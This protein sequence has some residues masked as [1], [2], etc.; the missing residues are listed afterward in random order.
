MISNTH[1]LKCQRYLI[2]SVIK[3]Y[4]FPHGPRRAESLSLRFAE[5]FTLYL[6]PTARVTACERWREGIL[7]KSA[8]PQLQRLKVH[9]VVLSVSAGEMNL[10]ASHV[11]RKKQIDKALRR[12]AATL[13]HISPRDPDSQHVRNNQDVVATDL[14]LA[15]LALKVQSYHPNISVYEDMLFVKQAGDQ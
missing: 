3:F 10:L 13:L 14:R 1:R 4:E 11:R 6:R 9:V 8:F 2:S 12:D 15:L 7:T 5:A